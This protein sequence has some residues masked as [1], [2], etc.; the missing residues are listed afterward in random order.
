MET[1]TQVKVFNSL[2]AHT[3][4]NNA[5]TCTQPSQTVP[6]QSMSIKEL[7][8]R[9]VQ[10]LDLQGGKEPLFDEDE[11]S[12]GINIATLDL[13]DLQNMRNKINEKINAFEQARKN[14]AKQA[15]KQKAEAK[16]IEDANIEH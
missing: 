12:D 5:L 13:V 4:K 7:L 16:N 1:K 9:H 3:R 10:G 11:T 8:K 2:N 6:D 15:E 14:K